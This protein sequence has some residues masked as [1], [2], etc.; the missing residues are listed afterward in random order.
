[1]RRS[2]KAQAVLDTW[3]GHLYISPIVS[4]THL[5]AR[6]PHEESLKYLPRS[7]LTYSSKRSTVIETITFNDTQLSINPIHWWGQATNKS[8]ILYEICLVWKKLSCINYDRTSINKSCTSKIWV[9][10]AS[11]NGLLSH[12]VKLL[13]ETML[14]SHYWGFWYSPENKVTVS[15]QAIRNNEF[16]NYTFKITGQWVIKQ[17]LLTW[18]RTRVGNAI[19]CL[20]SGSQKSVLSKSCAVTGWK[21]CDSVRSLYQHRELTRSS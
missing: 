2:P 1:M 18:V 11:S 10:I 6:G 7:P 8:S 16:E 3:Y 4:F 12:K 20:Q 19:S 13:P 17:S 21:D 14:I 15:T 5:C 9:N